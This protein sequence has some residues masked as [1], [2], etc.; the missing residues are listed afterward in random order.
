MRLEEEV[1]LKKKKNLSVM[2]ANVEILSKLLRGV[3]IMGRTYFLNLLNRIV[4]DIAGSC[5]PLVTPVS[6]VGFT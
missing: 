5:G 4:S 3:L 1:L 2:W 6:G